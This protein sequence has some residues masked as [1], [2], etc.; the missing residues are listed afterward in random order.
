MYYN[1]NT[2]PDDI[3]KRIFHFYGIPS[4]LNFQQGLKYNDKSSIEDKKEHF[5]IAMP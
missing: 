2:L 5:R 4:N 1:R 3:K